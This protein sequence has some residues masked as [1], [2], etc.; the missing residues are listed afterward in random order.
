MA[1]K[2]LDDKVLIKQSDPEQ[3]TAGGIVLPDTAKEKPQQ[4]KVVAIGPGKLL[5]S[6]KRGKMTVKKGDKV[7]YAM[8][9]GTEVKIDGQ[10]YVL[11]AES[12]VLAVIDR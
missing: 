3:V 4:G 1:I 6:G 11:I 5:E 8:Y 2:P 7:F 9:S 12:S 10:E